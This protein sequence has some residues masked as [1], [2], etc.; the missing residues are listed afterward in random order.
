VTEV[1]DPQEIVEGL[2]AAI[3]SIEVKNESESE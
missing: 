3:A 2:L 1:S